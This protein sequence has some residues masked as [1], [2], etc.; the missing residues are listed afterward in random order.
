MP[1]EN[2]AMST[3]SQSYQ[4]P[5]VKRYAS[6]EMLRIFSD[7][8]RYRTWRRLWLALAE[9]EA[10]LGLNISEAQLD[11]LRAHL[12]DIDYDRVA[13]HESELRHD[14]MAHIKTFG[15]ACPSAAGIIHLGATSCYVT[16]NADCILNRQALE[17]VRSRLVRLLGALERFALEYKELP[18]L[19][20]THFQPAQLTSVG[21]RA[22]IWAQDLL[23]DLKE[24]QFR[25]DGLRFR[26]V[27]GTTGTQ[28]SFLRLFDGDTDKVEALDEMVTKKMDFEA[29][30]R[31]TGQTYTR[32]QDEATLHALSGLAQSA[33]KISNDV[34]LLQRLGE[35]EEPFETRQVGSSAMPYKRNPMRM[36][37][38]SSLAK[39]VICEAQNGAWVHST[40]WF[41]RTLDDSAN[42]RLSIPQSFL[43]IDAILILMVNVVEG[44]VVYPEVIQRILKQEFD[45]MVS[46]NLM[47]LAV[48][49]GGDRQELH[50]S[51][52][53]HAMEVVQAR[54]GGDDDADL[55]LRLAE[56]PL[57]ESVR[58]NISEVSDPADYI[59]CSAA[60]VER[61]FA[62][63][64]R[65][66]IELCGAGGD[67]SDTSSWDVRV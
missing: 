41:E 28:A 55:L 35:M 59:G 27:K 13:Q 20:Y 64:V 49:A 21:K 25:L 9:S 8:N 60:Q 47:M 2:T 43:G 3:E 42:R 15:E 56:D 4:N 1:N 66:A 16:D 5:L 63:E 40:Q 52:R 62:E 22:A 36:E 57:F 45:L 51:I 18:A 6:A 11:E 24:V 12:D 50:E 26:G 14:V 33:H 34:R 48:K 37:R 7:D 46:E 44:L 30:F 19:A 53:D 10:E 32:K 61:F 38:V 54:R 58:E 31:V 17:L 23:L 39:F 29:R 67:D 65:P